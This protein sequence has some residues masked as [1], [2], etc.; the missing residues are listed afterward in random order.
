[1]ERHIFK[2]SFSSASLGQSER[3][4]LISQLAEQDKQMSK[5]QLCDLFGMVKS[6]Y[7]YGLQSK[8]INIEMVKLKALICQIFNDSK[9]SAGARSIAA[10]LM[11][12]H[13]IKL[14]RYLAAKIMRSMGLISFQL[15]THR[16]I[17]LTKNTKLVTI[18]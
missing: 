16:C 17:R 15:K 8:P 10:I 3:L 13:G 12:E 9:Q 5:T 6:S 1:M 2:K 4:S 7:Y 14:T 18:Y 11:N